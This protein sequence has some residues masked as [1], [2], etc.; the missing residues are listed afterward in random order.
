MGRKR[1]GVD[2]TQGG[3]KKKYE[4]TLTPEAFKVCLI[5]SKNNSKNEEEA[6]DSQNSQKKQNYICRKRSRSVKISR[7]IIEAHS[8]NVLL[9]T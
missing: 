8:N 3:G 9:D 2:H 7:N 4:Y 5:R 1:W 6:I